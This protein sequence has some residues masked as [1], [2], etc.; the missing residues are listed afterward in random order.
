MRRWADEILALSPTALR[1]LKQS[2]NADT[3]HLAGIG[4]ARV[5]GARPVRRVGG[6]AGGRARLHARS[7]S[8]TSRASAGGCRSKAARPRSGSEQP[9]RR[10]TDSSP[11][12]QE[13]AQFAGPTLPS[14][15]ASSTV[16]DSSESTA[17][18]P[19]RAKP[20]TSVSAVVETLQSE[21]DEAAG[22]GVHAI[23]SEKRESCNGCGPVGRGAVGAVGDAYHG[24]QHHPAG[25]VA[26]PGGANVR[27]RGADPHVGLV[28]RGA[29]VTGH[30]VEAGEA[31]PSPLGGHRQQARLQRRRAAR[32]P[33]ERRRVRA[34]RRRAGSEL[35]TSGTR[36]GEAPPGR[37]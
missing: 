28:S 31:A 9:L 8:P 21:P 5:H 11:L 35:G 17:R 24:R 4:P 15:P 25:V 2:F 6:G 3:E 7:A 27:G 26:A 36:S 29:G 33:V 19:S 20:G 1:F 32:R 30:D 22:V 12:P 34:V 13:G 23:G 10:N 16:T 18:S 37:G 14:G